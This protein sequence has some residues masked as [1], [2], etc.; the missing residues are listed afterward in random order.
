VLRGL[1]ID[2]G[3]LRTSTN[4]RRLFVAQ[5]V[6]MGG[7]Q[8]AV[9]AVAFQIYSLTGSSLQVGTVSLAQLVPF[10]AG[11][12]TGGTLSDTIDRRRILA[13]ASALLAMCS[14]GLAFNSLSGPHAS[15][16]AIYLVTSLAAWLAGILSTG[17]FA[18][19]PT[20]VG[21]GALAGA[22]A[23]MQV[24]DQIGMVAGPAAGGVLIAAIGLP[25]LYGIDSLTY[26]WAAAFIWRMSTM[27]P[28]SRTS[29]PGLR[30][31]L[32]G[33]RYVR[34]R[35]ELKG[36]Y[37]ADLCATLFGLPRAV[38]P[39]LTR[40]VFHGGSSTLGLLYAS[41]AAGA[42]AGSLISGWVRG[43]RRPGMAVLVAVAIW[44]SAI[45]AFGFATALWLAL[46][47]LVVAGWADVVSAVL[48]SIVVQTVV[49]ERYRNRV[50]ALQTAVVEGGPRLGDLESGAVASAVSPQ[51]SVVFGGLLCVA[52]SLI[53]AVLLPGFRHY[54]QEVGETRE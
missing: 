22:Y 47:L 33:F 34:G 13:F 44:G 25:W 14:A 51:F 52:G 43:I 42:L 18:A 35:Q 28:S 37:L 29:V 16:L 54:E 17:V 2:L 39:A 21:A 15:V 6:S 40:T 1:F 30:S 11:T 10:V 8:L 48:R 23:T 32:D 38:F 27:A 26:L 19:V 12:L 41:P 53:L 5:T 49:H 3:P 46:V 9:V 24:V 31:V 4:F 7:S 45:A 20:L 36:A 50:S